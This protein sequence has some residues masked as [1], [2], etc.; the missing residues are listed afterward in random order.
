MLEVEPDFLKKYLF[1]ANFHRFM[2]ELANY[3]LLQI[4]NT[5]TRLECKHH[6]K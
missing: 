2:K 5:V 6:M 3:K 4:Y 1:V